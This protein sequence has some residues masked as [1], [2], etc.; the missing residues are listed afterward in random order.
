M[1]RSIGT[2]IS[3]WPSRKNSAS[4]AG[5]VLS[6][7]VRSTSPGRA[8]RTRRGVTMMTRSVSFFWYA[9]LR[10]ERA[11]HRHVAEPGQLLLVGLC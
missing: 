10:D 7:G 5:C 1:R 11:E 3:P 8:G 4:F 6:S 2:V 9:A